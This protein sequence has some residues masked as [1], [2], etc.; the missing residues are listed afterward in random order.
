MR[1]ADLDLLFVAGLNGS[2]PDHWQ[3]RW[4]S[5]LPTARLVEPGDWDRPQLADWVDALVRACE[6]AER[7]VVLVAHSLGVITLAH[8]APMLPQGRVKGAFLVAAP[9][10]EA[11]IGVGAGEFTPTPAAPL[12]FPSLLVASRNDPYGA[13]EL[14]EARAAQWGSRLVAAGEA[15]HINADSGH[16]P[17]PEGL[18]LFAGFIRD[19]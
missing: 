17:W 16:G 3:T 5:R 10:D 15:G 19:L 13:Y 12:P 4:R 14:A 9:G 1:T 2:G 7:P 18:V 8:A 6:A 11:L